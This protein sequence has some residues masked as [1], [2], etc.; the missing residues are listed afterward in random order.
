MGMEMNRKS[1]TMAKPPLTQYQGSMA[2]SS[3]NAP[4]H[5]KEISP[6]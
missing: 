5:Q 4:A 1:K 3:K 2:L 6:R